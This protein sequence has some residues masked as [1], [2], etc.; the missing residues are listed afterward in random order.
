MLRSCA[1]DQQ[2]WLAD[3]FHHARDQRMHGLDASHHID[4]S[5][6]APRASA[7]QDRQQRNSSNQ[8][9]LRA[10][11]EPPGANNVISLHY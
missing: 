2:G 3:A 5:R 10:C 9:A 8:T 4:L 7:A 1:L 6:R 11:I